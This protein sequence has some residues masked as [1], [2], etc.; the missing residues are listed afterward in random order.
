M[1]EANPGTTYDQIRAHEIASIAKHGFPDLNKN[2]G[3]GGRE[4]T[5]LHYT[6][7]ENTPWDLE[8]E[9]TEVPAGDATEQQEPKRSVP[10]AFKFIAVGIVLLVVLAAIAF[11]VL[12]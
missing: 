1:L 8:Y 6:L 2:H 5:V 3:G 10:A 12:R 11:F 9:V 7:I 4:P